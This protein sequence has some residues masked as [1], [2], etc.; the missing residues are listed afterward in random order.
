MIPKMTIQSLNLE[1][2]CFYTTSD[3]N[4]SATK[5]MR[6]MRKHLRGDKVRRKLAIRFCNQVVIAI[7]RHVQIM[8]LGENKV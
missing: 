5:Y 7:R 3:K 1:K 2:I 4:F 6:E 8:W